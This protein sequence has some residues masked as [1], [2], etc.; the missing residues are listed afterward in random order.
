MSSLS[1][2]KSITGKNA[3]LFVRGHELFNHLVNGI[4]GPIVGTLRKQHYDGIKESDLDKESRNVALREYAK[5]HQP[6]KD[7][8]YRNYR[9]KGR[10]L[11]YDW[12]CQDVAVIWR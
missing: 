11:F 7:L 12:I 9:F 5:M 2:S 4:L 6:V 10:S 8:L 1:E 3:Y